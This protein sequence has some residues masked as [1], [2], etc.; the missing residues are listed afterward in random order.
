MAIVHIENCT[1]YKVESHLQIYPPETYKHEIHKFCWN[2]KKQHLHVEEKD[3]EEKKS[4]RFGSV[5][6]IIG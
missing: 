3:T 1:A 4:S 6:I 5:E 2:K